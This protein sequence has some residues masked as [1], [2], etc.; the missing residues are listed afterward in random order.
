MLQEHAKI[1]DFIAIAEG[2]TG[3]KKLQKMIY[4]MKKMDMP[5]QEKYEFHIYGPYSEELTARV[6]ELCDMGF[7]SEALE[8]KG[9]YVQYKYAVTEEGMEFRKVL[10][11][12]I[13]DTP[14]T[15]GKLNARSGRFL[16]LTATLLYFDNLSCQEQIDKLHAVKG[17]LNF[18]AEEIDEAFAFIEELSS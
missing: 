16:E 12:S 18:T 10:G 3:R 6:E 2:V 9:S 15:A 17:K 13:L 8:D 5:F 14:M 4:I 1:V 7:L 11:K